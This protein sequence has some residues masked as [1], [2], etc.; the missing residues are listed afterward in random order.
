MRI[1]KSGMSFLFS[2]MVSAVV[3]AQSNPSVR[4]LYD[5]IGRLI[6]VID[7]NG[8]IA[9][10]SYDAVGNL[11]SI[12]RT[13]IS[14]GSLA[15]LGFS[16]QSGPVGQTVTTEGQA[17]SPVP[18]ANNVQFNGTAAAV[19][20]ATTTSLTVTVPG[21]AT[22]GPL[23]VTVNGS[24]SS[25]SSPFT[26]KPTSLLLISLTPQSATVGLGQALQLQA[27]GKFIDG[28][29]QNVTNSAV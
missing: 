17:F 13:T 18:S 20:A 12:A 4:Y 10:Y 5:D 29:T 1:G 28:S 11:L 6:E 23:S 19:S 24:T 21:E 27:I 3:V 7:Q 16:P 25:S 26:V 8:N 9:T 22:T 15:V 14:S 2:V